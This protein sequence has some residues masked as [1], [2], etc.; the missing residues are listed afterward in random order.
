MSICQDG[1]RWRLLAQKNSFSSPVSQVSVWLLRLHA[2]VCLPMLTKAYHHKN[3]EFHHSICI[4]DCDLQE[5]SE[6]RL[7][8]FITVFFHFLTN[9]M[10]GSHMMHW[11]VSLQARAVGHPLQDEEAVGDTWW[12]FQVGPTC[13]RVAQQDLQKSNTT[14]YAALTHVWC[15]W[16]WN[17]IIILEGMK[18]K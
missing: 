13:Q 8:F 3:L 16:Y 14:I 1:G 10:E 18:T 15:Q 5:S 7:M 9:S 11:S 17:R 2:I 4:Q 12:L 6:E